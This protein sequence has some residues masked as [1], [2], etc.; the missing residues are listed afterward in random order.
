M[1]LKK[2]LALTAYLLIGITCFSQGK[3]EVRWVQG[4][5][6]Q[7]PTSDAWK[8][9]S[10]TA[11]PISIAVPIGLFAVSL[12]EHDKTLANNSYEMAAG[13]ALTAIVTQGLKTISDRPR[14]YYSY[15]DIY[16]DEWKD[17]SSFPSGHTSFAFSTA[18]SLA[19]HTKKWYITVPAF[20]WAT[21]VGY[22]R[23]YLGQHYP[24]DVFA[25]AIT[26]MAGAY[27][28]HWLNKKLF[29]HGRKKTIVP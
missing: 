25:G 27:A 26:G 29:N 21:S 13:L 7:Y 18:T 2:I 3:W 1:L 14:P 19:L 22:S 9:I 15:S 8:T 6:P 20:A 10:A 12:I 28:A 11:K 16:P 23:M 17:N 4:I 5:N 24:S